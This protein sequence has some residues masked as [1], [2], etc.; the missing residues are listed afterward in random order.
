LDAK[1]ASIVTENADLDLAVSENILGTLT[2]NGQRCT[3]IKI[4]FVHK[5][6]AEAFTAKLSSAIAKLKYGLPWE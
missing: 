4:I 5:T 6:I 2:Y 1:N 3:A